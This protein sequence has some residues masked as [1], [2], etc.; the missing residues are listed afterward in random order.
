MPKTLKQ[1]ASPA[2]DTVSREGG[3]EPGLAG[4]ALCREDG[5]GAGAHL[6]HQGHVHRKRSAHAEEKERDTKCG[7]AGI[8]KGMC[9]ACAG[10]PGPPE[11]PAR[12]ASHPQSPPA[13][14]LGSP[15]GVGGPSFSA[16]GSIRS[17]TVKV[18]FQR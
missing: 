8:S 7:E 11:Q 16:L 13:H 14:V 9:A 10:V 12:H 2:H 6:G 17:F 4:E 3:V 5:G 15:A 18:G 1:G